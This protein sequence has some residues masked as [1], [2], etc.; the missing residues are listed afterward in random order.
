MD[1]SERK[2]VTESRQFA[3]TGK[4]MK[5][6]NILVPQCILRYDHLP[7]RKKIA[8]RISHNYQL[9]ACASD[10]VLAKLFAQVKDACSKNEEELNEIILDALSVGSKTKNFFGEIENNSLHL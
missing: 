3:I 5:N 6:M 4:E 1:R 10:W 9:A 7:S 8:T 2:Y